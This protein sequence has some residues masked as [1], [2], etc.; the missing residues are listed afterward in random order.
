M[1]RHT[2]CW[3]PKL[4]ILVRMIT[5]IRSRL[6]TLIA[7]GVAFQ[8][9]ALWAQ[10]GRDADHAVRTVTGVVVDRT[11]AP[12]PQVV[13]EIADREGQRI[14]TTLTNSRG[15][16]AL[17]LPEGSYRVNA[18]LAGFAPLKELPLKVTPANPPLRLTLEVSGAEQHIIVTATRT[19]VPLS[20][21][22]SSVTVVSGHELTSTGVLTVADALRRIGGFHLAQN[23]GLG[24]LASLFVRGGESK[25]TKIL[26]D[27][28]EVNEPGGSFNFANLSTAA[29]DR[30][31]IVR[32]PQSALFGSDAIAGVIQIF[33]RR[34]ASEGLTPRPGALM[35]GG[36]FA[37]YR[38]A[39]SVEGRGKR[40]DYAASFARLE[41]DNDV[42]NGSFHEAT[43][44][45]NLGFR[46]SVKTEIRAVFRSETG[47]TG[48]PGQWAFHPPDPEEYYRRRDLAGGL[49]FT[50]FGSASWTQKISYTVSD[51][52]QFSADPTDSGSYLPSF[53]G[54]T[55]LFPSYD[56]VY[57]MLNQTRRQRITYQS[58]LILPHSHVLT[59]GT[60]YERESGVI[61]DP[62]AAPLGAI[63]NNFGIYLQD[64]WMLRNRV[65]AVAGVR[66]EHNDSFGFFATPRLSLAI[67]ARQPAPGSVVGLTKIKANFGMGIKEPTLVE[68]YSQSPYFRGNPNLR[69]EKS[70]SF[71]I[72]VEQQLASGRGA[73]EVSYFNNQFRDQIGFV[74]TDYTTYEG[75]FFN[76]GKSRA[77]GVEAIIR[78]HLGWQLEIAGTYTFLDSRI[79]ESTTAF[80]PVFAEGEALFRRPGHSGYLDLSWSPR[81]W[82]LA[83][84]GI[85]VGSRADSDFS[86]LGM[87]RNPGY[88]TLNL[89]ASFR[90]SDSLSWYAAVD[91]AL[92]RKYME[93]LGYPALRAHFRVGLRAG[94]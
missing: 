27:G 70:V 60:A 80:D 62:T 55:A 11:G 46:P 21:I 87:T 22:G 18:V 73:I 16:F 45:G 66:L 50:L 48:V 39:G 67:H 57:Q 75:T 20:Q 32:G 69:P 54:R 43:V 65:F 74:T 6:P 5:G 36:S 51:S 71:D 30:I 38:Y 3:L 81:R 13:V 9:C 26:I 17:E 35:E 53:D 25:Y 23:G 63:R 2:G 91:N 28:I 33:T 4:T 64:Q 37:T 76:L 59:A 83:A 72:G 93:V 15:E 56:F 12:L 78:Q 88:G 79:L 94:L 41:T 86:G 47:R 7:I 84:T 34:G 40:L 52:R 85:F 68:S 19:D 14:T 82:T 1:T 61:G 10:T 24:Q 92:N 31:E 89:R 49:A 29:V 8:S 90:I 58:D 77:R 44:T 42:L